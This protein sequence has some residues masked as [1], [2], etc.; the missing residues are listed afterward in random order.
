MMIELI[1]VEKQFTIDRNEKVAVLHD[2]SLRVKAN[3]C[4]CI[5]GP[6]GSGKT[7]M[8]SIVGGLYCP[9][10]GSA[11]VDGVKISRL[12]E[13]FLTRYRREKVGFIY[14][15]YNLLENMTVLQNV[16]LPLIPLGIHPKEQKE[17]AERLLG[18][19]GL[20]HRKDYLAANISGGEQQRTAI[21]RALINNPPII[22]GD[23]PTAHLDSKL[24]EDLFYHLASLKNEGKTM[25]LAS[26]DPFVL[27]H[28]MVDA[29][30]RID[31]GFLSAV[32]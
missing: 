7:T 23:E 8:L 32:S 30:Y 21:A 20:M 2:I 4:I 11:S 24:S 17:R 3:Q 28:P 12:P 13:L 31:N 1:R 10:S 14:Q 22:I 9:T 5:E 27:Q 25:I 29:R 18:R 6:S 26:H 15:H 16:C 19:F